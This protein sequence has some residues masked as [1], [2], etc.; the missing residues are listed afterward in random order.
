MMVA[1][2]LGD[3]K[4]LLAPEQGGLCL[5]SHAGDLAPGDFAQCKPGLMSWIPS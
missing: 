1:S 2:V 5:S 3:G 4:V